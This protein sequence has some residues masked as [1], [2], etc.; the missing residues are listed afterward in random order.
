MRLLRVEN[1]SHTPKE[2]LDNKKKHGTISGWDW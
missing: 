1:V 2:T